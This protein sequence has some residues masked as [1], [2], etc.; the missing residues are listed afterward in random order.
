METL[1]SLYP[2][3]DA[4]VSLIEQVESNADANTDIPS[5]GGVAGGDADARA[6]VAV[7]AWDKWSQE[8]V[9]QVEVAVGAHISGAREYRLALEKQAVDGKALAQA[10]AEAVRAGHEYIAAAVE[11]IASMKDIQVL[12]ELRAQYKGEE[13]VFEKAAAKFYSRFLAIRTSLV[14]E[15]RKLVWA[16]KY[17]A[18]SD[19]RVELDSQQRSY[20]F[21]NQLLVIATDIESA[22]EHYSTDYQRMRPPLTSFNRLHADHYVTAAFEY[23]TPSSS[24]GDPHYHPP[25]KWKTRR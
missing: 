24:V 7:A 5:L 13:E 4:M 22:D 18:L 1:E 9:D 10:D 20:E 23:I 12:K 25:L 19:S 15:M 17:N 11:V 14:I 16:Y 21:R 2:P 8:S 3:T 6:I